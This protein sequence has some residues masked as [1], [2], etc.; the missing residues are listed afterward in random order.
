MP[1]WVDSAFDDYAKRLPK[2]AKIHLLEIKTE[3][4]EGGKTT[5]QVLSIEASRII[6]ALPEKAKMIVLDERGTLI[7]TKE[8]ALWL[9]DFMQ[10]GDDTAFIIGSADGLHS[11]LKQ[12]A[13]R[14][15]SLSGLTL[16]HGLARVILAEQLYRAISIIQN[17]P[18]HRE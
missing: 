5:E 9:K 4:R 18:Y 13:Y 6:S 10:E 1:Q 12:R 11:S 14:T 3:K 16:P 2:E 7:S 15:L 8:L 17:H